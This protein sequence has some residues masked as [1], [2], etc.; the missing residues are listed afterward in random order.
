MTSVSRTGAA[1]WRGGSMPASTSNDSALRRMRV[2]RWSSRNRLDSASGLVSLDSSSV[3]KSSW[4]PS[5]FWLRRPR[6]TKLS[7]M[8]RRST[9]C[10]TA[11]SRAV[12]CT[13]LRASATSDTSSLVRIRTGSTW[14]TVM[15]SPSGV[16]RMSVTA[17]GSRWS[18]MSFAWRVSARSGR[19]IDRDTAQVSPMATTRVMT[20]I[21]T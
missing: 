9:A 6:L 11:R 16:S 19:V 2:A 21:T 3:M 4:R 7:A 5:R 13:V 15:F 12:S 8:L 10:S 20:A 18:A 1:H 14:G 17:S